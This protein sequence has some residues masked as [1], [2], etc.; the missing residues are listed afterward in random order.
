MSLYIDPRIASAV[1]NFEVP[2]VMEFGKVMVPVMYKAEFQ[3]GEWTGEQLLRYGEIKLDPAAGVMQY[4]YTLFEGLKA[5]KHKTGKVYL[6]CPEKNLKRMNR[7]AK[8]LMMPE[9]PK[10]V[11]MQGLL[12]V[13]SAVESLIPEGHGQS[14]YLRPF[15][16]ADNA[17][18]GPG[19]IEKFSFYV[20]ASLAVPFRKNS[21]KLLVER[22]KVRATPGGTGDVKIGANYA[23]ALQSTVDA[24]RQG[25]SMPLWLDAKHGKYIEELSIMNFFAVIDGELHTP[26]LTGTILPGITRESVIQLA[27][28]SGMVV[29]ERNM[30]INELLGQIRNGSCSE[31][32]ACG[33]AVILGEIGCISDKGDDSYELAV[34]PGPVTQKLRNELLSIQEGRRVDRHKWLVAV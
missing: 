20:I 17:F 1:D 9:L 18:L 5:F 25:Y 15:M 3:D 6:Y 31:A 16:F 29:H 26:S 12:A 22:E 21:L 13:T 33:T 24:V 2:K 19:V 30:D 27:R 10:T 23:I 32:F 11:F 28:D 34:S 7:S 14:L 4:A 8:R